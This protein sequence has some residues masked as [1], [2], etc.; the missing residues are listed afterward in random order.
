VFLSIIQ[1]K[2]ILVDV[3]LKSKEKYQQLTIYRK[4]LYLPGNII[5]C[6]E[7]LIIKLKFINYEKKELQVTENQ[8]GIYFKP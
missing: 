1:V 7:L 4:L 6:S 2:V 8:K 5:L 3:L